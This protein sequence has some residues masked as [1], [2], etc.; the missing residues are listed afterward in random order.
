M[1][2]N[3]VDPLPVA[4]LHNLLQEFALSLAES[5]EL[6]YLTRD[7]PLAKRIPLRADGLKYEETAE[8]GLDIRWVLGVR[9]SPI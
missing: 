8:R 2:W 7:H 4:D 3:G 9:L 6:P 1:T 5:T